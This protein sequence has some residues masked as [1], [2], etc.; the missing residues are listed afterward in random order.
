MCIYK[1]INGIYT[2]TAGNAPPGYACLQTLGSCNTPGDIVHVLPQPIDDTPTL[3]A[4]PFAEGESGA[5][6]HAASSANSAIYV[7]QSSTG[8]LHFS[9]GEADEGYG[10]IPTLTLEELRSYYPSIAE[11]LSVLQSIRSLATFE[12]TIPALPVDVLAQRNG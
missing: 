3:A 7:Y 10:F 6:L 2:L 4:A 11:E 5:L 12:L 8:N 9:S 1:C